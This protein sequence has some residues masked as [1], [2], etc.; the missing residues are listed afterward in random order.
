MRSAPSSTSSTSLSTTAGSSTSTR[1]PS[2]CGR[3]TT[4]LISVTCPHNPTGTM[5]D[6]ASL[7][8]ARRVGRTRGRGA[9][10][11]R[12]VP[13]PHARRA[14]ADGGDAVAAR[15]QRRVDVEGVRAARPAGRMGRVP[16]PASSP[17]PCSRPRSRWSSAARRSTKRSPAAVLAD[18]AR[19]LPPILDDVRARLAIV[20]AWMDGP[21]HVR[22]GRAR[23]WGR[24]ASCGSA[25]RR[26]RHRPL[27]RRA[28]RRIRHVRRPGP[29]VRGRR[30]P[31]PPR[32][33]LADDA[34]LH[35]GLA[36]LCRPRRRT[37]HMKWG[38]EDD[39]ELDRLLVISPHLD[40][41]VISCGGLLLAHP[42][43]TVATLFA[44]SPPVY[45]DPLNE[46]DT[47][48]G[49]QPGDDTM[50]TRRVE[51]ERAARRRRRDAALAV[52]VPEL[53]R[54][55]RRSDRGAA[56]RGR[57]DRRRDPRRRTDL[58]RR[59]ARPV[60][61]RPP[62]VPRVGARGACNASARSRGSGTAICPTTSSRGCSG[63][64]PRAAQG[65]HRGVAR[66]PDRLPRL[67]REAGAC[68]TSTR[69]RSRCSTACGSYASDSSAWASS[70]G[71]WIR[72]TRTNRRVTDAAFAEARRTR[73]RRG[74]RGS[75]SGP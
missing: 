39:G 74:R 55:A 35:A 1:S 25:R 4:R 24:R 53:A 3:A 17:R 64:V 54:R 18:R 40:D 42:G 20:R 19:I 22:V 67:R 27:L 57:R 8:R 28:A 52:A 44:A 65:R 72:T 37:R 13:R 62:G 73:A 7:A 61:R 9:A 69:P 32:L 6:L 23:G 43:A 16:R 21:G 34:E 70:T 50:A 58:R 48:C 63:R 15:D 12:D 71:S 49:F 29:L 10:R 36:A 5:L 45:T 33:R 14:A 11:R 30:P 56:G 26:G 38:L 60:A 47:A 2:T 59:A 46:H 75:R 51:D 41:V 31:L 68:S 66:V